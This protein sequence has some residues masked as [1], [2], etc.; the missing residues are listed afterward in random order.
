MK[1]V[2]CRNWNYSF[3]YGTNLTVVKCLYICCTSKVLTVSRLHLLV[4][5]SKAHIYEA[6]H[7]YCTN[8][9]LSQEHHVVIASFC[10]GRNVCGLMPPSVFAW[11][12]CSAGI[13]LPL[14]RCVAVA[15][16]WCSDVWGCSPDALLDMTKNILTYI[17][18]RQLFT[19]RWTTELEVMLVRILS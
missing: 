4:I 16:L 13:F 5:E 1:T 3:L 2:L 15:L 17:T 12:H 7:I 11:P 19:C 9:Y 18:Q 8:T 6:T 10:L 14:A